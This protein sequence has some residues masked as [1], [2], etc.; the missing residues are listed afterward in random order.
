MVFFYCYGD[1]HKDSIS[2]NYDS[3]SAPR[4]STFQTLIF[5]TQVFK[6]T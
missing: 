1:L 2:Y 3:W 6:N 5:L 4:R